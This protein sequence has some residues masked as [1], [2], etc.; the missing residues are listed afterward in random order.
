M[1]SGKAERL[2]GAPSSWGDDGDAGRRSATSRA[3]TST[4]PH[5]DRAAVGMLPPGRADALLDLM[6]AGHTIAARRC[7]ESEEGGFWI[8]GEWLS[9]GFQVD[10][11]AGFGALYTAGPNNWMVK[12]T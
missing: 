2:P 3:A 10:F 8:V 4:N 6:Q 12:A 1:A 9:G 7:T 11:F 5:Y